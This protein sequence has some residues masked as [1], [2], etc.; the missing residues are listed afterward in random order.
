MH[1][2]VKDSLFKEKLEI[3]AELQLI[4]VERAD[5]SQITNKSRMIELKQ[6]LWVIL[7]VLDHSFNLTVL[8]TIVAKHMRIGT[9]PSGYFYPE[10]YLHRKN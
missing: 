3:E 5:A 1:K 10:L 6:R 7:G 2:I 9:I 8:E 4:P